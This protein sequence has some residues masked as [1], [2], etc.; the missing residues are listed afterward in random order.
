M[1]IPLISLAL[2]DSL[3]QALVMLGSRLWCS[4]CFETA[5]RRGSVEDHYLQ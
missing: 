2:L 1:S 3:L 4:S 5:C